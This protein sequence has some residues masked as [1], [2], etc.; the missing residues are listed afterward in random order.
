MIAVYSNDLQIREQSS[1]CVYCLWYKKL[2][3]QELH[4][5]FLIIQ[6]NWSYHRRKFQLD[7][8]QGQDIFQ[9]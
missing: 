9:M 1:E 2:F 6:Q 5:A 3:I 4:I 8:K 7:E